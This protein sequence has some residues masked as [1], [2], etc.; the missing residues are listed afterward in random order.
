MGDYLFRK[1]L[2]KLNHHL[3]SLEWILNAIFIDEQSWLNR[4]RAQRSQSVGGGSKADINHVSSMLLTFGAI[5]RLGVRLRHPLQRPLVDGGLYTQVNNSPCPEGS[6]TN[7]PSITRVEKE[8]GWETRKGKKQQT[9]I[10]CHCRHFCSH[11]FHDLRLTQRKAWGEL[12]GSGEL[13]KVWKL[14][15]SCFWK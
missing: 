4:P 5:G 2:Q 11:F 12:I 3:L 7:I 9:F 15:R 13:V 8:K 14:L 10:Y 1:T 6:T